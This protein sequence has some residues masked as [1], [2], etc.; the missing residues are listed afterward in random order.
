[1]RTDLINGCW[2][3]R[4]SWI[5]VI[6]PNFSINLEHLHQLYSHNLDFHSFNNWKFEILLLFWKLFLRPKFYSNHFRFRRWKSCIYVLDLVHPDNQIDLHRK[7]VPFSHKDAF[8]WLTWFF[9]F[10]LEL[11]PKCNSY[12]SF[13]IRWFFSFSIIPMCK[14][15]LDI[16]SVYNSFLLVSGNQLLGVFLD[17]RV[18]Y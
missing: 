7:L 14:V 10:S 13:T 12:I 4:R 17:S 3:N 6:F 5:F 18:L 16:S 11:C 2:Q 15:W 8:P 1:M 9:C